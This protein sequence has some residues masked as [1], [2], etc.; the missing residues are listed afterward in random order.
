LLSA[1]LT[2]MF[3]YVGG[4]LQRALTPA[5][6]TGLET[7]QVSA[8]SCKAAGLRSTRALPWPPTLDASSLQHLAHRLFVAAIT[9][10]QALTRPTCC[11][12]LDGFVDSLSWDAAHPH[13]NAGAP[14]MLGNSRPV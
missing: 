12:E 1:Y 11:V 2:Q 7:A 13:C 8:V 10:S 9:L 4:V 5:A 6:G 14:E 3:L